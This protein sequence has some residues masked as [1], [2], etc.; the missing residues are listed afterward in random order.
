MY[1]YTLGFIKRQDHILMINRDHQPWK[2]AWNGLGGKIKPGE[3]P[4]QG[5]VREIKEETG[6]AIEATQIQDKGLLTWNVFNAEGRGLY[7]FLIEVAK[8]FDY[9]TPRR[10]EEGILEWKHVD[11]INDYD[12]VGMAANIPYFLPTL[13]VEEG[14]YHYDCL[15][16]Q[17]LLK[18]VSKEKMTACT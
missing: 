1:H 9:P 3:T 7:L 2:G 6:I 11:W 13:L 16:E 14:R 17:G 18:S 8:D 10:T 15:F 4:F 5:M 12:N